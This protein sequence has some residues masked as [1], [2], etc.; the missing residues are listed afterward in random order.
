M[1]LKE[2]AAIAGVSKTVVSD[3]LSDNPKCSYRSETVERVRS[4]ALEAGYKPHSTASL[5]RAKRTH[6]IGIFSANP[7]GS[8]IAF[9]IGQIHQ[10]PLFA[11]TMKWRR[12]FCRA[13]ISWV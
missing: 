10:R 9:W 13:R 6:L 2:V 4:T 3:I 8:C 1:T 7:R 11:T 12:A 5:M